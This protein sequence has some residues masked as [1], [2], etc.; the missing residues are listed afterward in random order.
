MHCISVSP[1]I[2][3]YTSNISE[4]VEKDNVTFSCNVTSNPISDINLYNMTDNKTLFT[5]NSANKAKYK[6]LR[7]LC[8]DTGE[9]MFT[10]KNDIPNDQYVMKSTAYIDIKCKL[11]RFIYN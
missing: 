5:W 6:F 9:Y 4:I 2:S 10:A 3:I 11:F 1:S 8:L 7:V